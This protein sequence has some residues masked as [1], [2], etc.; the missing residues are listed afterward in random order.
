[1]KRAVMKNNYFFSWR[2]VPANSL[3]YL[4][5]NLSATRV[6]QTLCCVINL[7]AIEKERRSVEGGGGGRR[8]DYPK[9]SGWKKDIGKK[10]RGEE[11]SAFDFIFYNTYFFFHFEVIKYFDN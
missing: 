5:D 6:A 2:Q 3:C 9:Q 7:T 4:G 8:G 10:K 11:G 1:M